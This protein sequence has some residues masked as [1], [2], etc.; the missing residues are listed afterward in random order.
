M[1][2]LI[3]LVTVLAGVLVAGAA[4]FLCAKFAL[5][6][7]IGFCAAALALDRMLDSWERRE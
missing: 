3:A 7:F 5:V 2:L 6:L 4:G 1:I